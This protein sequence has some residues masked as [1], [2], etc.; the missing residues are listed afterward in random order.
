MKAISATDT[1]LVRAENQDAAV[2]KEPSGAVLAVICDGMGGERSGKKAAEIASAAVARFIED[3]YKHPFSAKDTKK[4]MKN[5]VAE[6]NGKVYFAAM[7][8]L[9]DYGMGTTCVTALVTDK[10]IYII[11]VGDSRAYLYKGGALAQLTID[12]TY[13]QMLYER[14]EIEKHELETHPK[15]NMLTKAVGIAGSINGD[16]F[17]LKRPEESFKLLLCSDGLS[18]YCSCEEIKDIL[19]RHDEAQEA[20]DELVKLAN[21]KGGMDNVTIAI[22]TN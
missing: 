15:R 17:Y 3:N 20:A 7:S 6:A 8:N 5:A 21:S 10:K 22:V 2:I 4:L 14:G 12:H 11:N 1:G 16:F 13:V 9:N 18:G 19:D